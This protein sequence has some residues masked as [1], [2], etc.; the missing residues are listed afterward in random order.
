LKCSTKVLTPMRSAPKARRRRSGQLQA[1]FGGGHA[2]RRP[3]LVGNTQ[4]RG[5]RRRTR[6]GTACRGLGCAGWTQRAGGGVACQPQGGPFASS[7]RARRTG[8]QL[9]CEATR[10]GGRVAGCGNQAGAAS[11]PPNRFLFGGHVCGYAAPFVK[12]ARPFTVIERDNVG[13]LPLLTGSYKSGLFYYHAGHIR[14]R[15][16]THNVVFSNHSESA[17]N[18]A[19]NA[20]NV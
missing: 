15:E 2:F 1:V 5:W 20:R 6:V 12:N 9:Y 14:V 19:A 3:Q 8:A 4:P 18:N 17:R 16:N 10:Y 11:A 7:W 13:T